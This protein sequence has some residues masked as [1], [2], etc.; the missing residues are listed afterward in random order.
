MGISIAG[1]ELLQSTVCCCGRT[2]E[3][4]FAKMQWL[5]CANY[6]IFACDAKTA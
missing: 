2:R 6:S 1:F 5:E 3:F 4:L